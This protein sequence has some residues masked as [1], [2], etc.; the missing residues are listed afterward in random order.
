LVIS[1]CIPF[2]GASP[3]VGNFETS[4]WRDQSISRAPW[5]TKEYMFF[6]RGD[7]LQTGTVPTTASRKIR[8]FDQ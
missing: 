6:C 1:G 8:F 3:V 5:M 4:Q 2:V 7:A